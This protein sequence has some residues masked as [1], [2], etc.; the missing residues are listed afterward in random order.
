MPLCVIQSTS[1][2]A[3]L[4]QAFEDLVRARRS[5]QDWATRTGSYLVRDDP[6][7]GQDDPSRRQSRFA[8]VP[9]SE[10][11]TRE[12][13]CALLINSS[14]IRWVSKV[15]TRSSS[16]CYR[17]RASSAMLQAWLSLP[18]W[19]RLPRECHL[20]P[21]GT[22]LSP[23]YVTTTSLT[24]LGDPERLH[25][26]DVFISSSNSTCTMHHDRTT[27]HLRHM[28]PNPQKL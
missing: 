4:R 21:Q 24:L 9:R 22:T 7:S 8:R 10:S 12:G 2:R 6:P 27:E 19:L 28:V 16:S 13:M 25:D 26:I 1:S 15:R 5:I 3:T 14:P 17:S 20:S 11:L 23:F 18:F